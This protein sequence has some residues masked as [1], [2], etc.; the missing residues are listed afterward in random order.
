MACVF[1]GV[2]VAILS[3]DQEFVTDFLGICLA[4]VGAIFSALY[5]AKNS[6][7]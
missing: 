3:L 6:E 2:G 5:K 7:L 1:A 4:L